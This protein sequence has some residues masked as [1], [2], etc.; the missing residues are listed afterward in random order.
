MNLSWVYEQVR[1]L[2]AVFPGEFGKA[3]VVTDSYAYLFNFNY[4]GLIYYY[5]RY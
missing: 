5:L 1:P 3:D 4:F 2:A